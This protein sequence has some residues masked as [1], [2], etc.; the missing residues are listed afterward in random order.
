[1]SDEQFWTD[2]LLVCAHQI[3]LQRGASKSLREALK[4]RQWLQKM[5]AGSQVGPVAR[6]W[7]VDANCWMR[8]SRA[9]AQACEVGDDE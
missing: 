2:R 8:R 4:H 9:F 7:F 3:A 5:Y 6:S 1:M